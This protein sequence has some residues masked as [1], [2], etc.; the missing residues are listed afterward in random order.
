MAVV[1]L[2]RQSRF[3]KVILNHLRKIKYEG[4]IPKC[5]KLDAVSLLICVDNKMMINIVQ[6]VSGVRKFDIAASTA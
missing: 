6:A 1:L 4:A 5:W 2:T 3:I